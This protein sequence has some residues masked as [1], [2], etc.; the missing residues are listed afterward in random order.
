MHESRLNAKMLGYL[1]QEPFSDRWV[2]I[3]GM[4]AA[5]VL[6]VSF[7]ELQQDWVVWHESPLVGFYICSIGNPLVTAYMQLGG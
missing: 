6:P 5:R 2:V 7:G 1:A 4:R 3:R